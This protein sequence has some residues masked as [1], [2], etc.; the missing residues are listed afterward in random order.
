MLP[1]NS[2]KKGPTST[3]MVLA[4][5]LAM[6]SSKTTP[7]MGMYKVWASS[8]PKHHPEI[9]FIG[10]FTVV[11][12]AMIGRLATGWGSSAEKALA[13]VV[14]HWVSFG[15]F[16]K[17]VSDLKSVPQVPVLEFLV[18]HSSM[19][20]NFYLKQNSVQLSATTAPE[21]TV[22][23]V[24][25][26]GKVKIKKAIAPV[27]VAPSPKPIIKAVEEVEVSLAEVLSFDPSES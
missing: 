21:K 18:K 11:Q 23:S 1:K 3:A 15:K 25:L 26:S 22:G 17:E 10:A 24:V 4:Q 2:N 7:A 8:I 16:L 5:K 14:E 20:M 19:A 6:G 9:K 12:K 13:Y 27:P